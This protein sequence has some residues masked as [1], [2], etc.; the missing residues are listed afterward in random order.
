M[1][2]LGTAIQLAGRGERE[3]A[4]RLLS[5]LWEQV[6]AD[7]DPLHR[8]AL[9]HHLADVQDEPGEELAW[10]QRALQAADAVTDARAARAGVPGPAAGLYPSLHLNVAEGHRRLGDLGAARRHLA[11]GQQAAGALGD[12]GYARVVRGGLTALAARLADE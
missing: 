5:A 4:R 9:A 8:C 6:G 1:T 12:D 10:D 3:Q 7:G 2:R 11:L